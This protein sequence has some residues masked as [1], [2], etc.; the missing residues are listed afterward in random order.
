M[1]PKVSA[2]VDWK[3]IVAGGV[4]VAGFYY[5]LTRDAAAVAKAAG[6]AVVDTVKAVGTAVN[7]LSGSNFVQ[8]GINAT[9]RALG[10]NDYERKHWTLGG[11]VFD[12]L[13]G[14]DTT[15]GDF[16]TK[17]PYMNPYPTPPG[18]K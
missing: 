9:G 10:D 7:P 15:E 13:H 8:T 5:L 2:N 17:N 1:M 16:S 18:T 4:V 6:G 12:V 11:A 14:T 3:L